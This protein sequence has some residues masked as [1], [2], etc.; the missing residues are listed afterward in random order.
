MH[1]EWHFTIFETA[2]SGIAIRAVSNGYTRDPRPPMFKLIHDLRFG[3][4]E[5]PTPVSILTA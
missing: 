3:A 1:V 5:D 2:P 4:D